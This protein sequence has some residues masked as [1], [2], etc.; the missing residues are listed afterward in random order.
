MQGTKEACTMSSNQGLHSPVVYIKHDAKP[1]YM[2]GR[3]GRDHYRR[4]RKGNHW[5]NITER[6]P[7]GKRMCKCLNT[8][9]HLYA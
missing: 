7:W 5:E 4:S 8:V 3:V 6:R 9:E 2:E 1:L